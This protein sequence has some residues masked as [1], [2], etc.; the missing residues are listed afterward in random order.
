M[1]L[2]VCNYRINEI[3][4]VMAGINVYFIGVIVIKADSDCG[5]YSHNRRDRGN[6][7]IFVVIIGRQ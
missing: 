3:I 1:V 6:K 5:N 2:C 4:F 7:F